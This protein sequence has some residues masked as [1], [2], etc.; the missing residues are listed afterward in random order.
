MTLVPTHSRALWTKIHLAEGRLHAASDRFWTHPDLRTLLPP[1]LIQL[2]RVMTGGL[3]LMQ[4]AADRA[5]LIPNDPVASATAAYLLQHIDEEKDHDDWLLD[6]ITTLNISPAEVRATPP[7]PAVISLLGAQLFWVFNDHPVAVFGYL[8]VL[9]GFAPLTPQLLAI[10]RAT[11]LPPTAFRCLI[12][13]ADN[14]P[15]HLEDLNRTLDQLPLTSAQSR[16]VAL[17]AFHTIDAV[18]TILEEL[19]DQQQL[20]D[21]HA[22]STVQQESTC[23]A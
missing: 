20:L 2:H 10:Q 7:L 9:E 14:D 15:H 21:H 13:H 12:A 5:A 6:D 23:H 18:A 16:L 19:L 17:S 1:F 8:I 22:S 11:G 4:A 3:R